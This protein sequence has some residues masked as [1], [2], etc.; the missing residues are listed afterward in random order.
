[1]VSPTDL[2]RVIFIVMR[3]MRR[4]IMALLLVY[5]LSIL[6]M[7]FV[8][9]TVNDEGN[10]RYM[11]IF[12]SFYFMTY[13][14]TTTG[15][16]EIPYEFSDAQRFWSIICLYT[17]VITW[18]YAIGTIV[19]LLQNPFFIRTLAEWRFSRNVSNIQNPYFILCGFGDTGSVLARGLS[20]YGLPCVIIDKNEERIKALQLRN[21]KVSMLGLY[22]DASIPKHLLEAGLTRA[23][24]KAIV[25]ITNDDEINLKISTIAR[26]LNPNI[27]IITLSKVEE[28]EDTLANLGG[29]FHIVN[30]FKTFAKV[31]AAAMH[32]PGFFAL[33]RWLVR[34]EKGSINY[35]VNPPLGK[36]VICGYGR[37]GYEI[38]Q[39][40]SKYDIVA[41]IIDPGDDKL[42]REGFVVGRTT[43]KTLI[44]AK[45]EEATGLLAATNDDGH[46]LAILLNARYFNP[47]LF[48]IARQNRHQ[49]EVAFAAS[50]TDIIMQPT[51]VTAR[52]ILFLLVAPLLKPFFA[53]LL[54]RKEGRAEQMQQVVERLKKTIGNKQPHLITI[55][56]TR[57]TSQAVI[58]SIDRG[59]EVLLGDLLKNPDNSQHLL[60]LVVFVIQSGDE[61]IILPKEDYRIKENDQLLFC[62]TKQAQC[63]FNATLNNEYKLFY[64]QRGLFMPGSWITQWLMKKSN[65]L[66]L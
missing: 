33:N 11:S 45:I 20:D 22:A 40:L 23:N 14:A 4:P 17:S 35:R 53:Y 57:K 10:I 24:C 26:V 51:L 5:S 38:N 18:I 47:N 41:T 66:G 59:K 54:E 44:K 63:L 65:R 52:K 7:T 46:N 58:K 1:M 61:I 36:W 60:A 34:E 2:S 16:G 31:L 28:V 6:G 29:E 56:F 9:G 32:N 62:G 25:A 19:L 3:E 12:H 37:M 8:P 13:T 43:S 27:A 30:P 64:I 50:N 49:N 39:M 48:T 21:Y 42:E 15:F 55:N